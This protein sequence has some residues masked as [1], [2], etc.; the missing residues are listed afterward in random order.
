MLSS[1]L[2][3]AAA[4]EYPRIVSPSTRLA[5]TNT[6]ALP[7]NTWVEGPRRPTTR[8]ACANPR[9]RL[10]RLQRWRKAVETVRHQ[11]SQQQLNSWPEESS[12]D[13]APCV[14]TIRP[15]GGCGRHVEAHRHVPRCVLPLLIAW[16]ANVGVG[17]RPTCSSRRRGKH[18]SVKHVL[19]TSL[20]TT[21]L[22]LDSCELFS[23][24]AP[25]V[26]RMVCSS[27]GACIHIT[28][29]LHQAGPAARR[30]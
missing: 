16:A 22:P 20:T 2:W 13:A 25:L 3:W 26:V 11:A 30:R 17:G 15:P 29:L 8:R 27:R 1:C 6:N 21:M 9:L 18:V 14:H 19:E 12:R 10:S 24:I 28:S 7:V 5:H 23:E 4:V